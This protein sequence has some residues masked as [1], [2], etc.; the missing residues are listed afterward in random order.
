MLPP[1]LGDVDRARGGCQVEGS[2]SRGTRC[3]GRVALALL[4]SACDATT[5]CKEGNV[6]VV[7]DKGGAF[8]STGQACDGIGV[9]RGVAATDDDCVYYGTCGWGGECERRYG[10][11]AVQNGCRAHDWGDCGLIEINGAFSSENMC[12]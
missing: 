8:S 5:D 1:A 9:D 12:N 6:D 10:D 4:D 2:G 7:G 3:G 11:E